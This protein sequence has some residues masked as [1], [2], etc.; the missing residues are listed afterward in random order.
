MMDLFQVTHEPANINAIGLHPGNVA[1]M[2]EFS[3]WKDF[4]HDNFPWLEHR[5][6]TDGTFAANV[7][8]CRLGKGSLSIIDVDAS[9]V[10]R[11]R[12]LAEASDAG[13]IKM[14][15]QLAGS[16]QLEQDGQQA[17]LERGDLSVCDT[18]RPYRI[19]MPD[20][21]QFAVFMLP[22]DSCA[23]WE[24][25]SQSLCGTR[26]EACPTTKGA[27]GAML[28]MASMPH[29]PSDACNQTVGQAVELMLC[30]GLHR[31]A[32]RRGVDAFQSH[33]LNKA[34]QYI[35][36]HLDDPEL[37]ANQLAR[38][39]CMSRR[40]LYSLFK[41]NNTSPAK[42]ITDMRLD[43]CRN[44]LGDATMIRRKITDLAYDAG[45]GD[46]ATFSRLFKGRFG[47]TP[48]DYRQQ[49]VAVAR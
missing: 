13:Y 19:V 46:Y 38:A 9:E 32:S 23:G 31:S 26:L 33:R 2:R 30:S 10:T 43:R 29:D 16:M 36:D 8:A 22:Y 25:I 21:A 40:S 17:R 47:A 28:G 20:R 15:W 6:R 1:S 7:S 24:T 42:M 35:A 41:E 34:Q 3:V 11:T 37:N 18:A 44:L 49:I 4:V 39:L 12:H 48:R 45:F 5:N 14:I 27:L